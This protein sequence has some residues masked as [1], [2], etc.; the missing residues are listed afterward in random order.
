MIKFDHNLHQ[1][2]EAEQRSKEYGFHEFRLE[3]HG[4]NSGPVFD[5]K[6][7]LVHIM[8][9]WNAHTDIEEIIKFHGD[10]TKTY[11][12]PEYDLNKKL[13]CITKREN[14]IYIILQ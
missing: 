9:D 1:I 14:S 11:R 5:R 7:K 13:S 8:G 2:N 3:D 10:T 12:Y 4:R 6:G